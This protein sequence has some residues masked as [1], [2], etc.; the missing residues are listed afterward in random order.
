MRGEIF[1]GKAC[2]KCG[3]TE[4]YVSTR[5]CRNCARILALVRRPS[6][7]H[8]T[9]RG[10]MKTEQGNPCCKCGSTIKSVATGRCH[11]CKHTLCQT[12]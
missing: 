3:G 4:R 7:K 11:A 8:Y 10:E 5:Q 12:K 2:R 9:V 6:E 1:Q